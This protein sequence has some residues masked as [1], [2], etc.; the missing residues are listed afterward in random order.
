[1][2]PRAF[3]ALLATKNSKV[4]RTLFRHRTRT[5]AALAESKLHSLRV[6]RNDLLGGGIIREYEAAAA[7]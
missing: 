2:F 1:M 5:P 6:R 4:I 3:D 7:A